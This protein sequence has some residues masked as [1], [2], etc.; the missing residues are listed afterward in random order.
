MIRVLI[1]NSVLKIENSSLELMDDPITDHPTIV[2]LGFKGLG[3]KGLGFKGRMM[4]Y[5]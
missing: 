2:G 1:D 3:F 4:Y 5:D